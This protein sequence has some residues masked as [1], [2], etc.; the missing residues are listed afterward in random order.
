MKELFALN[1]YFKRYSRTI[2][3]GI[4][5]VLL[6]NVSGVLVPVI[7]R[8]GIDDALFKTKLFGAVENGVSKSILITGIF[9]GISIIMA[10]IIKGIFMYLMRQKIIVVSRHIE[11]DLKNDIY[12]KYQI[13][14]PAFYRSH[15]TGDLMARISEDVSNVR[16]YAG[17]AVLYLVNIVFTFCTVI[18]QMFSVNAQLAA[19]VLIP[20]P[21]LS[22]S[23]YKVSVLINKR[24]T[25]IQKQLSEITSAAQETF[26]GIRVI[27]SFGVEEIF[28]KKF[29]EESITYR[30]LHIRLAVV[31]ALFFPLMLLLVGLSTLTVLYFGGKLTI[32]GQ[33]TTGNIAE[34]VLYLN[35]LIWPVASLG[36]TTALVQK[37]ASSQKRINEFL[38]AELEEESAEAN[39]SELKTF[40]NKIEF[41][42]VFLQYPRKDDFAV[43]D[44]NLTIEKGKT[45]GITGP[46]GCGKSSV[47]Q[48][49]VKMYAAS[50]G[51]IKI[52]GVDLT[53]ITQKSYSNLMGYVPQ[54]VF[55]FS[56]T[57]GENIR[58]GR[59][60]EGHDEEFLNKSINIAAMQSDLL[61][62][63]S[64][65]E[66][67]LGER[68]ITLSG[69]QKQRVSIAR[70]VYR[71]ADFYLLD[72][73]MSAV[74]TH[75]EKLIIDGLREFLAQKT[76][77]IIS[78]R[79]APLEFCDQIYYMDA[80]TIVESGTHS[81]LVELNGKYS[82]LYQMQISGSEN[83]G[84][85]N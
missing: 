64:G 43:S 38:N 78:H 44:F 22:F 58:F 32:A 1:V 34:F 36:Y 48:L 68:G 73:C 61:Q 54:D 42:H 84:I 27:K 4:L 55:L 77:L 20:L 11:F 31:N 45:I 12:K 66:T 83:V 76:C 3:I 25:A 19:L 47:A 71:N 53:D 69:G 9:F 50:S 70:A 7:L 72:D 85:P 35:L 75:T 23:I 33:F 65:M 82:K 79:L 6:Y 40:N 56:D 81:E 10:A 41:Q 51:T 80:G 28:R 14:S 15:Q 67:V 39:A 46:T 59:T 16:M 37:A 62:F 8:L 5:C 24:N 29:F 60:A 13:L 17:P 30:K 52:D 49:L 63:Q 21:I 2:W 57:I 26:A 18:F 74:D